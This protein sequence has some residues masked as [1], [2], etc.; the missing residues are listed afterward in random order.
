[1]SVPDSVCAY[2][3]PEPVSAYDRDMDLMHPLRH[4]MAAVI[5]EVLPFPREAPVGFLDLG[6]G[7]GF[8]TDRVLQAWPNATIIAIDG[9]A[10]MV[11][12]ARA[13]LADSASRVRFVVADFRALPAGLCAPG[14]LDAVVSAYA[15][16]HLT[17]GEKRDLIA[18]ALT[19]LRPGGWFLN[20]D[21][22]R[23]MDPAVEQ[24]IQQLRVSGIL[25]RKPAGDP[26]FLDD[27]TTRAFLDELELRDQD[28]PLP[29][30]ED[31]A[32][33]REAGL[34]SAEV[35]WKEYR[36]AVCGGPFNTHASH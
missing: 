24:R 17:G 21:L 7:T 15:L 22:T 9:A 12:L 6:A 36:E 34:V 8:L 2:D 31:I 19:W 13:R 27:I 14:S 32:L 33:A 23:A 16:H 25:Q 35:L 4:K 20:A 29:L 3:A 5:L 30:S 26:R 11:E 1:M 18:R 10:A 28:R